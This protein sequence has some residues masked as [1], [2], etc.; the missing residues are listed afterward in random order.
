MRL[1]R[2][3]PY[4]NIVSVDWTSLNNWVSNIDPRC[5]SLVNRLG[6]VPSRANHIQSAPD[7][8]EASQWRIRKLSIYWERYCDGWLSGNSLDRY[9]ICGRFAQWSQHLDWEDY[10]RSIHFISCHISI[11]WIHYLRHWYLCTVNIDVKSFNSISKISSGHICWNFCTDNVSESFRIKK[12]QCIF[13][14][15][16]VLNSNISHVSN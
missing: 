15:I 14:S 1:V 16:R 12:C 5:T 10:S 3:I 6:I 8:E 4:L 9:F 11:F 13:S 2:T 7:S